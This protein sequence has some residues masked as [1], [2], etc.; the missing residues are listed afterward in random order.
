MGPSGRDHKLS[1]LAAE[2]L[3][4]NFDLACCTFTLQGDLILFIN[5]GVVYSLLSTAYNYTSIRGRARPQMVQ[6]QFHVSIMT[7]RSE[8]EERVPKGEK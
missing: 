8:R 3:D 6:L 7:F 5:S 2:R 1:Q 4:L